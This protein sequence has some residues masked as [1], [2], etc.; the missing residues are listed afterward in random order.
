MNEELKL[1]HQR[2]MEFTFN[3]DN[4]ASFL[5]AIIGIFIGGMVSADP[6]WTVVK[7]LGESAKLFWTNQPHVFDWESFC[8][9][10]SLFICVLSLV[11]AIIL[12]LAVLLPRLGKKSTDSLIYFGSI[13]ETDKDE[14]KRKVEASDDASMQKDYINQ[15]H[16]CSEICRK[17]F[18]IYMHAVRWTIMAISAFVLFLLFVI[19]FKIW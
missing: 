5:G 18:R 14:Y 6:F 16:M 17:K 12:I 10:A 15:V 8:V 1:A 2:V 19:I 9:G 11:T 7:D 13:G 4:K 3:C